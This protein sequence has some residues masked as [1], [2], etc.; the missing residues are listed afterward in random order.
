MAQSVKHL[1]SAQVMIP[2]CSDPGIKPRLGFPVL[3]LSQINFK[4]L[5]NLKNLKEA[6][7]GSR[8]KAGG[9]GGEWRKAF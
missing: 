7:P 2:G 9:G 8:T 1:S 6:S 5:K 4:S 3:A